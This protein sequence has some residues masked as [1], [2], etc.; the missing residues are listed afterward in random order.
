MF[1]TPFCFLTVHFLLVFPVVAAVVALLALAVLSTYQSTR[2]TFAIPLLAV[3]L[4]A[5]TSL[6]LED[7]HE[8]HWL[9]LSNSK[10]CLFPLLY[11]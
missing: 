9:F 1:S 11:S 2:E 8:R 7:V 10:S 4:A 5:P 6:V 3:A